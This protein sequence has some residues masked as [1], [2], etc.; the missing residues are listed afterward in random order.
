VGKCNL[1]GVH[2]ALNRDRVLDLRERRVLVDRNDLIIL[3]GNRQIAVDVDCDSNKDKFGM[4]GSR[5][6]TRGFPDA[7]GDTSGR[8]F[9]MF[10]ENARDPTVPHAGATDLAE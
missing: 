8:I 1:D 4:A 3:I 10:E 5:T 6:Y 2:Q 9:R 7:T